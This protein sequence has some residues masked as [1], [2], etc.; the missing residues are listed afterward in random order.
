[1]FIAHVLLQALHT[2]VTATAALELHAQQA[3]VPIS[4][5]LSDLSV[6]SKAP[7]VL[8]MMRL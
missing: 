1:M 3:L 6:G 2:T 4:V 5:S 8:E 7:H